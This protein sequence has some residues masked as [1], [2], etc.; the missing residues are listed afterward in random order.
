MNKRG[1]RVLQVAAVDNTV[2][3][4][5]LPLI[6]RLS[7]EGYEVHAV[8]SPSR[9]L[10]E[11]TENGYRIHAV[12]IARKVSL[13]SNI[14]SFWHL[15]RLMRAEH[16]DV[17]HVHTPVAAALGRIAAKLARVPVVIYT[18]HGFYF[19]ELMPRWK[20]RLII[21]VERLL[22]RC[23]TDLLLT[24]S[25]EDRD[26]AIR[27]RIIFQKRAIW[28]GNGVNVRAFGTFPRPGLRKEFGLED[29]E[30]VVGFIGRLVR[31]KGIE[32]LLDAMGRV[33]KEIPAAKLLVVGDTLSGRR[34]RAPFEHGPVRPPF[35]PRGDAAHDH[36]S[37]GC[38]EAGCGDRYPRLPRGGR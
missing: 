21:W 16:F 38:G 13:V 10:Q 9:F 20:K 35:P 36:R 24:Q 17:V 37:D 23:C 8:C 14:R 2:K 3:R 26:T 31:E 6:D 27:E 22:G 4:L 25:A 12:P 29:G 7:V 33:V 18:A 11:L 15:Y 5:L 30:K 32:E 34:P 19:H 1:I 28:I